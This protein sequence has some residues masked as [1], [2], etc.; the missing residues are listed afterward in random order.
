MRSIPEGEIPTNYKPMSAAEFKEYGI[1]LWSDACGAY[2]FG[3][4]C[5]NEINKDS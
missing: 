4:K 3:T 5:D 2:S 1:N